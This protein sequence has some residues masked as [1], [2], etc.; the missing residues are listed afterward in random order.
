MRRRFQIALALVLL[1]VTSGCTLPGADLTANAAPV[2]VEEGAL[3]ATGYT[4]N[5]RGAIALNGTIGIAGED[6]KIG[7]KNWIATYKNTEHEGHFAVFSTPS[8]NVEG[9]PMN[10][11]ANHSERRDLARMFGEVFNE[12][13]LTVVDRRNVTMLGQQTEAVTYAT[14]NQTATGTTPVFVHIAMTEHEGDTVI[15]VSVHPQSVDGTAEFERL[16][17]HLEHGKSA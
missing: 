16:V 12:T 6:R 13:P 9:V 5:E 15:A 3:D 1:L 17:G 4:V 8:P 7:V 11:F 10:P 14:V 2:S